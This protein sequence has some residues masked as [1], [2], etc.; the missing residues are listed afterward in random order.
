[1]LLTPRETA[2]TLRIGETTLWRLCK[3]KELR[4]VKIGRKVLFDRN[5]IDRFIEL[6]KTPQKRIAKI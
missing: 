1:M 2:E 5:D 6:N 4:A 3:S